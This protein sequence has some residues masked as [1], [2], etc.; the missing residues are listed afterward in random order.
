VKR[1]A[2]AS[3]LVAVLFGSLLSAAPARAGFHLIYVSEVFAGTPSAPN[4]QFVELQMY[5]GG[6]SF[7]QT[8]SVVVYNAAGSELAAY[9]FSGNVGNGNNQASILVA[10]TQAQTLFGVTPDLLMT[11]TILTAGGKVCF[12]NIDCVS[13]GSYSGSPTLP[14]PTGTPAPEFCNSLT[15]RLNISGG[16]TTLDAADDTNNSANDFV[17]A[18]PSPRNN[19]GQSGTGGAS[20]CYTFQDDSLTVSEEPDGSS[21]VTGTILGGISGASRS[22]DLLVGGGSATAGSDYQTPVP[23]PTTITFLPTDS[24]KDFSITV[25]DDAEDEPTE[26]INLTLQNPSSG[27][28]VLDSS[29]TIEISDN[30]GPPEISF[31]DASL[32]VSESQGD[33]QV[34]VNRG[35]NTGPAVGATWTRTAATAEATI[36]FNSDPSGNV[37][38]SAGD[39]SESF[40]VF[41]LQD[42][43]VEGDETIE[44]TL[45]DATAGATLVAPSVVTITIEDDD[46]PPDTAKPTSRVTKPRNGQS[47]GR[48]SFTKLT[49]TAS[50][51][52]GSGLA[53]V[54]VAIRQT[55]KNGTCKW[56]TG[57]GFVK[58]KCTAKRWRNG[59]GLANWSVGLGSFRLPK[60]TGASN[61]VAF[62]TAFSRAKDVA[63]NVQSSFV[64]KTNANRFEI[65]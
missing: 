16:P 12:D 48:G 21:V 10:S 61:P 52:G 40:F 64:A 53:L 47:Y 39:M 54:Q 14:S 43:E 33:M 46:V 3:I 22:V 63:G 17:N 45:S 9:T 58:A 11:P 34:L 49:G 30:D 7:V 60:S 51:T 50:D 2:R 13:W 25:L 32:T 8:H 26:T 18:F 28:R 55:L 19:A 23:N 5:S 57:S 6:Q 1:P 37:S 31:N 65:V 41:I 42:T 38:F 35:G 24:A 56:F 62:Y 4:A 36:D 20:I 15:R 27:T 44:F 29:G 59:T